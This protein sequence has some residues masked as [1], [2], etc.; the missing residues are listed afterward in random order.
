MK[1]FRTLRN[2]NYSIM[3]LGRNVYTYFHHVMISFD[4]EAGRKPD[5]LNCQ[6]I[7][8]ENL[9]V[10]NFGYTSFKKMRLYLRDQSQH[11]KAYYFTNTK[12]EVIGYYWLF[13]K[14]AKELEYKVKS[15]D[16]AL[17]SDVFVVDKCR[18]NGYA[19][20]LVRHACMVASEQGKSAVYGAVRK[21]NE[22]AFKAY[23]KVGYTIIRE[24]RFI[25]VMKINIPYYSI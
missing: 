8:E 16:I 15:E 21:N 1:I 6:Q 13:L 22:N 5:S 24:F 14:G 3:I 12:N 20:E 18:G 11:I 4:P 23:K 7:T 10:C 19:E 2:T 9:N 17:L 25:R